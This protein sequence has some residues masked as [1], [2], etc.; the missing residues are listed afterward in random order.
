MKFRWYWIVV[1]VTALALAACQPSQPEEVTSTAYPGPDQQATVEG[2][3]YPAP[4]ATVEKI[5]VGSLYPDLKDGDEVYWNQAVAMIQNGEVT[6]VMQAHSLQVTLTLKD[7]RALITLEPE[8][9]AVL[10]VITECGDL[11]QGIQIATE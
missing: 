1:F 3:G 7:G 5:S 11:C 2:Q 9:D 6:K 8:M 4:G 10:Q